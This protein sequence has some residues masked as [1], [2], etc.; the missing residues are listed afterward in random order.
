[1]TPHGPEDR[2]EY[3]E[4][5]EFDMLDDERPPRQP[6]YALRR[7]GVAL[8]VVSS[9]V[10]GVVWIV[11]RDGSRTGTGTTPAQPWDAIVLQDPISGSVSVHDRDG[12]VLSTVETT[13]R[14]VTDVGAPGAVVLGVAG[15][16][17]TNGL[18]ILDL[19]TG[20]V[21]SLRVSGDE[22]VEPAD[23]PF[24][25][26]SGSQ[27]A[28]LELVDPA[29]R[30]VT[31][32]LALSGRTEALGD[33]DTVRVDPSGRM[34]AYG[35][36]KNFETVLVSLTEAGGPTRTASVPGGLAD[37]AFDRVLTLTNRGASVL[38]DLSRTDGTRVGTVE[39]P[40]TS[41]VMLT[42]ADTGLAVT[43]DGRVWGLRFGDARADEL[44]SLSE[45]LPRP[46]GAAADPDYGLVVS[47]TAML[48]HRRMAL[49]GERFVAFID[50]RGALVRSVDVAEL[51]EPATPVHPGD[52]CAVLTGP[53]TGV[54]TYLDAQDGSIITSLG[55]AVVRGVSA[56]G[57]TAAIDRRTAADVVIGLDIDEVS[58]RPLVGVSRDGTAALRTDAVGTE[59]LL[60]ASG[61]RIDLG[62]AR[63]VGAFA[64]R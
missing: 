60:L 38:V 6:N 29:A 2:E 31:D 19:A 22:V 21:E 13:L 33:P 32:L 44:G 45:Q 7:A 62:T 8:V 26:V 4:D 63:T 14:G 18:G 17:S 42:D 5:D 36:L 27:G 56:D 40:T 37:L 50:E 34:L 47:G 59:V 35:E 41:A 12:E 11:S 53:S 1:M 16:P 57:C 52:R 64:R 23:A 3:R 10:A 55:G 46:P 39:I 58:T 54:L 9:I 28:V 15:A 20:E 30:R 51:V 25:V 61:D 48:D 24:L 49:F 43:P